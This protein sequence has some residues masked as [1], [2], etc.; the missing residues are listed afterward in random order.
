M[1]YDCLFDDMPRLETPRLILRRLEMRDAPDLFDYSRDPQVAKH[2]LW[3]AQTSV[4]EARAYVRYMLR[5]YRAG[6]PASWGIEEKETGRVVGTIGY[7]WYQRD[8]NA[9]EVGYSLARRRWNR[10][11]MTEALT[12]VLRFSFEELGVHRVEAQHEVENAASGAVMRKCGM[13]KEGTLRGRL[14][15]KGRYVDVDLYAML[16]ED[17]ARWAR[18][19]K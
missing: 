19:E 8:N 17:Y 10:G 7:M 15:N 4:S 12:E 6:E 11:Y 13:R 18:T 14:Y 5:R 9:C 1:F 3:D 2:V 16:R